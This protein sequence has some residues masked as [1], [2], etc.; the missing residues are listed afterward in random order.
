MQELTQETGWELL[1][2]MHHDP[3]ATRRNA[4]TAL[5]RSRYDRLIFCIAKGFATALSHS[6]RE[7]EDLVADIWAKIID[8]KASPAPCDENGMRQWL[9]SI[10]K[11]GG[12]SAARKVKA[13][14]RHQRLQSTQNGIVLDLDPLDREK[15]QATCLEP[16]ESEVL[17]LLLKGWPPGDISQALELTRSTT[18][19]ILNR[20]KDK[21]DRFNL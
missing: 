9:L 17:S 8:K 16:M 4:A 11:N 14:E 13:I 1:Q 5:L 6:G 12:I 2:I 19:R 10:C 20:I 3:V 18:Y 15:F 7:P 21:F